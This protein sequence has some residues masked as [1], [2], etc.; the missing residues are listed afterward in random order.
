MSNIYEY[1]RQR[2]Q[3][4]GIDTEAALDI[5]S[6]ISISMHCWQGDDVTGFE[7]FDGGLDGGI[8][9]TGNYPGRARTPDELRADIEMALSMIPGTHRLNLH[10]SYAVTDQPVGRDK[11]EPKH[12]D[13]WS[14]WAVEKGMGLDFNPTYFS[15]P[16]VKDGLTLSSPD[17]ATR[18]YWIAHGVACR[19]IAQNF[20]DKTGKESL[21]NVWI[22]DGLKELPA[23][24]L[25]PR[26][27]L[28]ESLDKVFAEKLDGVVDSVESKVFGIGLESY[29]VG[30]NEFYMSYCGTHKGVYPLLD[31]GH[32]H[33]TETVSDKIPALLA[34][35]DRLPLHV[36]R[37]VR[38]DS[39]HVVIFDDELREIAKELVRCNAL[40][41]AMI[42]LDFFDASINRVSAWVVGVRNMQ[43]A[44]L[45]ALL[46]PS[47]A[48]KDAQDKA[49]Y[50]DMLVTSEACKTLP[51]AVVW[52]EF[53]ARNNKP[54]DTQ[55]LKD[56][57][58]Y[59]QEV[60]FKR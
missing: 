5:L 35:Y 55:W 34:F 40:D 48:M 20:A 42:G 16:M 44:L 14:D 3:E 15:H 31:N 38:W 29:T 11:L 10:A 58:K 41:K 28:R 12:F 23:D 6:K 26:V 13:Y 4:L 56:V 2:Y 7:S 60:L 21:C 9:A 50:T 49:G 37:A 43:K 54:T 45:Y 39:D 47:A 18:D 1:A 32:Y 46:Q 22:P 36:T 52:D 51:W 19:R 17:K 25:G 30:S 53:L 57:R 33:P 59:E 8:Q 24:R 27:R